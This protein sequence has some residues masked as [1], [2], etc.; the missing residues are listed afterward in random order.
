MASE[1]S[2]TLNPSEED[3]SEQLTKIDEKST[4]GDATE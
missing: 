4:P 1:G 2:F 3:Q